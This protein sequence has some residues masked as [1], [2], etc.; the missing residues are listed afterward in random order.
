MIHLLSDSFMYLHWFQA[1]VSP[2]TQYKTVTGVLGA[3]ECSQLSKQ[4]VNQERRL[5][6]RAFVFYSQAT[7]TESINKNLL[8]TNNITFLL[9]SPAIDHSLTVES[10]KRIE[11]HG[12]GE[13]DTDQFSGME[14]TSKKPKLVSDADFPDLDYRLL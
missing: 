8:I 12:S 13:C 14:P 7:P 2:A 5:V 6:K 11:V 10:Q 3:T 9:S 4:A 1:Q